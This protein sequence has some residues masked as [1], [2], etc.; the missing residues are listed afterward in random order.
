[1]KEKIEK[2]DTENIIIRKKGEKIHIEVGVEI[3]IKVGVGA[4]VEIEVGV[5]ILEK[6]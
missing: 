2:S 4:E 6:K 3:G 5:K 1:M